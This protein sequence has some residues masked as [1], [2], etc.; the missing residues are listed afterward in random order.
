MNY[1]WAHGRH[2]SCP[3]LSWGITH[4]CEGGM[5]HDHLTIRIWKSSFGWKMLLGSLI[6][7]SNSILP[8]PV[9]QLLTS[10]F[11]FC[12]LLTDWWQFI[13]FSWHELNAFCSG[14]KSALSL[15]SS[16]LEIYHPACFS[17][18]ARL[19]AG[20]LDQVCQINQNKGKQWRENWKTGRVVDLNEP[21]WAALLQASKM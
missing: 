8:L 10:H 19:A 3:P 14:F 12:W 16:G 7:L 13:Y 20:Y 5:V 9:G 6:F 11:H 18:P 15:C 17:L 21:D 2:E 4:Q 1:D